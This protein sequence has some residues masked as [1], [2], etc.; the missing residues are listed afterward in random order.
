MR[1]D[2]KYGISSSVAVNS[3]HRVWL[4]VTY[5]ISRED[6]IN[7][8]ILG[9]GKMSGGGGTRLTPLVLYKY[10]RVFLL[11]LLIAVLFVESSVTRCSIFLAR[12]VHIIS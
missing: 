6:L 7:R 1:N 3:S 9:M 8:K 11:S 12:S 4:I 2:K 5:G 10:P